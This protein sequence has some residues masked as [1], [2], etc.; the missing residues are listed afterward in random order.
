MRE[1]T[2]RC[3]ADGSPGGGHVLCSSNSL[4]PGCKPENV[5]A[6]FAAAKEFGRYEEIADHPIAVR[7]PPA[8][9]PSRPRRST[10]RR[11]TSPIA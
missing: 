5:I 9:T 6:M 4:H 1:A 2:R 11:A 8:A 10:R 7:P 3:I